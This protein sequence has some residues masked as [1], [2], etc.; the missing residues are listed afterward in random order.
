MPKCQSKDCGNYSYRYQGCRAKI[1]NPVPEVKKYQTDL[2]TD[3]KFPNVPKQLRIGG[4]KDE[5]A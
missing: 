1:C 2:V 5:V 4:R 3:Y